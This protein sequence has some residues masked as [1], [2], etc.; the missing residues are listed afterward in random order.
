[1]SI[2]LPF[3]SWFDSFG[4]RTRR[5]PRRRAA[6][7]VTAFVAAV[8][9]LLTLPAIASATSAPAVPA[10]TRSETSMIKSLAALLNSE[11][12]ANHLPALKLNSDLMLSARRHDLDMAAKNELSHQLP[13]EAFFSDRITKAGYKWHWAGENIAY[14]Q[15]ITTAGVEAMEKYMYGE[16][17]PNDG[18]RQNILSKHYQDVGVDV[19]VDAK[20]HT[21]WMTFDFGHH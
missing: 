1:V 13:K 9:A 8:A 6:A 4:A 18:H 10:R 17:P 15:K 3:R 16:K 19:Y 11:R 7:A 21:A 12:K 20:H 5:A 14:T 2:P